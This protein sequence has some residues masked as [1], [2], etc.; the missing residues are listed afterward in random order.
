[1]QF[2]L[3]KQGVRDLNSLPSPSKEIVII[4]KICSHIQMKDCCPGGCN[5][6]I[7]SKCGL[8]WDD[9]AGF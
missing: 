9:G 7:C 5:H 3:T 1:M 8:S 2:K 6:Y 4:P